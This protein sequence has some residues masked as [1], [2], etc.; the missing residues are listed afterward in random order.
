MPGPEDEARK[1][2]RNYYIRRAQTR[3]AS[4]AKIGVAYDLM[5]EEALWTEVMRHLDEGI[6]KAGAGSDRDLVYS[7]RF[8]QGAV[9][10]L[11]LRGH[12]LELPGV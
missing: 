12:Q 4:A 2:A 9:A 5:S 11:M 8:A 10:E 1:R 7:L 6:R 3:K